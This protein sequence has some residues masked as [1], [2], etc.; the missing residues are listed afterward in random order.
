M[1]LWRRLLLP[2]ILVLAA[3]V[4][5]VVFGSDEPDHGWA[6]QGGTVVRLAYFPNVTHAPALVGV[7]E[8]YWRK[9]MGANRLETKVVNAGPEAMEA[10]LAG[11]IDFAYVGPSPAINTYVKSHGRALKIIAGVCNGGASLIARPDAKVGRI[12]D[13]AGKSLAVPQLG[14]TQDVSA[15][16]FLSRA[17][18]MPREKGGNV[19]VMPVK[20]G[21]LLG[22]MKS[23]QIDAAWVPEPWAS[24]CIA[25]IGAVRVVDER[26]L[27][28][29]PFPSTVLVVRTAFADAHPA[30]VQAAVLAN[31]RAVDAI[32]GHPDQAKKTVNAELTRLTGKPIPS[33]VLDA[34]WSRLSFSKSVAMD[35]LQRQAKAAQATGYLSPDADLTGILAL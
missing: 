14:G 12:E 11:A 30:L 29:G 20:N 1:R 27:W 33:A 31:T 9:E 24:R 13:L 19:Q 15:R 35:G 6:R 3:V 5:A 32:E 7:A 25:E 18:L 17:G 8:G 28:P 10:L 34:A 16:F 21:D 22:L 23:G 2:G 4:V 26:D